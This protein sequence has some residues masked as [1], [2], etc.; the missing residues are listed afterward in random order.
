MSVKELTCSSSP[1]YSSAA[2]RDAA[3]GIVDVAPR[4]DTRTELCLAPRRYE[5]YLDNQITGTDMFYLENVELA[6]QL[7]ELG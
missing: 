5:D 3:Y 4:E 1:S 2:A 6:R 7:V